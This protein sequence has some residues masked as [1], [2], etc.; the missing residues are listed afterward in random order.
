[1]YNT[2]GFTISGNGSSFCRHYYSL[3]NLGNIIRL[4]NPNMKYLEIFK[5]KTNT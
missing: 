2:Y 4:L 3:M 5:L 1:M